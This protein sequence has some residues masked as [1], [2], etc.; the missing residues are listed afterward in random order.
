MRFLGVSFLIVAAIIHLIGRALVTENLIL[1]LFSLWVIG[2]SLLCGAS[3]FAL[4]F[5]RRSLCLVALLT[6]VGIQI[7]LTYSSKWAPL[8]SPFDHAMNHTL[9]RPIGSWE[10]YYGSWILLAIMLL[11]GLAS[12]W[13][14]G[15]MI[16]LRTGQDE[17]RGNA[18][19]KA[20]EQALTRW[21]KE[22]D[23]PK[24]DAP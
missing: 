6:L 22:Q 17:H 15:T 10:S 23:T 9:G 13:L 1:P 20:V 12:S 16:Y 19:L 18:F 11:I 4:F 14:T 21:E 3:F 5:P 2:V 7:D 24:S 8:S